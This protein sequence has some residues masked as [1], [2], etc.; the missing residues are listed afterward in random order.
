MEASF[1]NFDE[2]IDR[3]PECIIYNLG[4]AKAYIAEDDEQN[5]QMALE[6]T[7]NLPNRSIHDSK[8]KQTARELLET[9][10]GN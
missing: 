8:R 2:A 4:L 1:L 5:A 9:V 10:R 3:D 7:L 6:R